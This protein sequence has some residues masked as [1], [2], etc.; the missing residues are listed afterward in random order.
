MGVYACMCVFARASVGVG[1]GCVY[2]CKLYVCVCV[3]GHMCACVDACVLV[4]G[5]WWV[6]GRVGMWVGV[7]VGGCLVA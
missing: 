3:R 6:C 5:R 2:G 4:C 1:V 7:G